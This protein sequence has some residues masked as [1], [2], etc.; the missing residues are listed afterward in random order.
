M[1]RHDL[2]VWVRAVA[3]GLLLFASWWLLNTD[4]LRDVV[5]DSLGTVGLIIVAIPVLQGMRLPLRLWPEGP[6]RKAF[7]IRAVLAVAVGL[8]AMLLLARL[9]MTDQ[10]ADRVDV[11]TVALVA[12]G[13]VCWGFGVA[14]VRQ[15]SYLRWYGLAFVLALVPV[16][17]GLFL[18]DS[19]LNGE[20]LSGSCLLSVGP[21]Q[22]DS[23]LARCDAALL[24]SFAFLLAL[25]IASRLVTEE[26][27]FR[28]LL[29]GC[30]RRTGLLWVLGAAIVAVLWSVVLATSGVGTSGIV[31]LVGLTAVAAGCLYVLSC[32]LM[33]STVFSATV[34]AGF[35]A[36]VLARPHEADGSLYEQVPVAIWLPLAVV[37][38]GLCI[39]V[40]RRH[41]V[42]GSLDK[43]GD[44]DAVGD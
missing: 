29:I 4:V 38:T 23:G 16:V 17:T 31:P 24:P 37:A 8:G 44:D 14:M 5:G 11:G 18:A 19:S 21:P 7:R 25:G 28:R 36:L 22:T 41:G 35:G 13:A 20:G 3:A 42:V 1:S 10:L 12:T 34:M 27:A 32:S 39:F 33:V 6:W 26:L 40:A 30:A 15:R 43:Q 9:G 2:P